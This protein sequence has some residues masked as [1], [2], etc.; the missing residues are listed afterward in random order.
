MICVTCGDEKPKTEYYHG[1]RSCKDCV[2]QVVKARS[3]TNP[4]VQQ[5]DRD[6]AK[7]PDRKQHARAITIKWRKANPVGYK[8]Q[9]AISN[10]V[11]DGRLIKQ[12]C[13]FCGRADVHAHHKDYSKPLD[14][15][16]LCPKCH[17]RLHAIFPETEGKMKSATF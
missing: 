5:Y 13:E 7:S 6:R 8:A 2:R 12:P 14:V 10:A 9:T 11:R 15:V 16:W 3:R 17:H 4:A 1:R